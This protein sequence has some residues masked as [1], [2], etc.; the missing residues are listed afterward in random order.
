[1]HFTCNEDQKAVTESHSQ[2]LAFVHRNELF[3]EFISSCINS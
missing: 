2:G 1:M 3:V